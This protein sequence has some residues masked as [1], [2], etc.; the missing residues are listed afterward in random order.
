MQYLQ[1]RY[2]FSYYVW[3]VGIL[4]GMN[5]GGYVVGTVRRQDRTLGLE[6]DVAIVEKLVDVVYGN[7]RLTVAATYHILVHAVSIHTLATVQWNEGWV[8]I[9]DG[10]RECINQVFGDQQQIS[11]QYDEVDVVLA[12]QSEYGL[13]VLHVGLGHELGG[14][15]QTLGTFEYECISLVADY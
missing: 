12:E 3:E 8:D 11:G 6:D 1:F 10:V 14:N 9:D 5:L 13:L 7:A 15:A 4:E 2:C